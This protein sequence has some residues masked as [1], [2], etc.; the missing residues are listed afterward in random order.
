[1]GLH[2]TAQLQVSDFQHYRP[3]WRPRQQEAVE[4]VIRLGTHSAVAVG[5]DANCGKKEWL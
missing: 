3:C 5:E 4:L 1:M 2:K